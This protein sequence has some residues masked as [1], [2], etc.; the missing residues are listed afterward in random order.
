MLQEDGSWKQLEVPGPPAFES[1]DA[2]WQ[3]YK[4]T[5]M[6]LRYPSQSSASPP[7]DVVLGQHW[8]S[9]A[10]VLCAWQRHIEGARR[11]LSGALLE[12]RLPMNLTFS[13]EQPWVGAFPYVARD[14]EFWQADVI[15]PAQNF[16]ARGGAGKKMSKETAEH[17]VVPSAAREAMENKTRGK[18]R[19]AKRRRRDRERNGALSPRDTSDKFGSKGQQSHPRK[20][21]G[22][23]VTDREGQQLCLSYAQRGSSRSVQQLDRS[24]CACLSSQNHDT[25]FNKSVF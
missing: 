12:G 10:I 25:A 3:I 4:T 2:C 23:F 5:L 16:L 7:K 13:A 1:W 15:I 14:S 18:S 17:H 8:T 24:E 22:F 6:M 21:N 9:T 11:Q 20:Q 19:Q